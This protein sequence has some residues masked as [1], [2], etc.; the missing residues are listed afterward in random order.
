MSYCKCHSVECHSFECFSVE[1]CKAFLLPIV[2]FAHIQTIT[3][4]LIKEKMVINLTYDIHD[5]HMNDIKQSDT[6][7]IKTMALYRLG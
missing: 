6:E 2:I 4:V 1:C 5:I 7:Q 3:K